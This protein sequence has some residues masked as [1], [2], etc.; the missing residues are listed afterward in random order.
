MRSPLFD[1]Y[2]PYG[3]VEQR[4]RRGMLPDEDGMYRR[5]RARLEDLMPPEERQSLLSDLANR[6]Q[7]AL[8]GLGWLLDVPGSLARG[9]ID[10]LMDG[11]PF[12]GVRTAFLPGES[13]QRVSGRDLLRR[14]NLAGGDDN[15]L[16][17]SAGLA[18]EVVTDPLFYLNP[19]AI[20]GRGAYSTA[21]RVANRA[22][23][24]DNAALMAH[25]EGMGVRE[26][27][28]SRTA[29]DL[30]GAAPGSADDWARAGG[31][32]SLLDQR[33]AG[34]MEL[35]VPGMDQGA[36]I[37]GGA[38]GDTLARGLDRFGEG[39]KYNPITGP[40][41]NRLRKNFDVSVMEQIN[42]D[43]QW[44][45]RE[46]FA[47]MQARQRDMRGAFA[48]RLD[49]AR[50]AAAPE[51]FAFDRRINN[52]IRDT[53]ERDLDPTRYGDIIDQEALRAID[54]TPAW[55]NYRQYLR[56]A[57]GEAQTRRAGQGLETPTAS[58][59]YDTA[60]APRQAVRF[61]REN[62]PEMN[63][64]PRDRSAYNRG[65]RVF[66]LDDVVGRSRRPYTD[67][68]GGS[69]TF[70]RLMGGPDAIDTLRDGA[71][72]R[73]RLRAAGDAEIPAILDAEFGRLGLEAPF[74]RV[75]DA[76]QANTLKVQLGDLL[77]TADNQYAEQGLGLFDNDLATD[78]LRYGVGGARSEANATVVLDNLLQAATDMPADNIPGG[79][80][81]NLIQ[82]ATDLGFN[83]TR[84]RDII[85]DR[86][87]GITP[88]EIAA[89]SVP[90]QT[91]RS[92]AAIAPRTAQA[93]DNPLSKL[94]RSF[95]GAFKVGALARPAYH[96]RNLYSGAL[97][98]LSGGEA[99]PLTAIPSWW[100]GFQA[101][102]GNYQ[103]A[104][105]IL[106]NAPG[107]R[108]LTDDAI[109]S[110]FLTGAAR[111][112]MS[113]GLISEADDLLSGAAAEIIPGASPPR[114]ANLYDS[115]RSLP[116][117]LRDTLTVRGVDF[118]LDKLF[119]RGGQ[120]FATRA[121]PAETL[122]PLLRLHEKV[123]THI[124]DANRLGTYIEMLRRGASPDAAARQVIKTQVDY[125]PQAYTQ[126]ERAAKK[127]IPFYSYTRGITPLAV[128]NL[129][130]RPGG[131]QGQTTRAITD[132]ARPR[133]DSFTPE[134]LRGTASIPLPGRMGDEGQL[135]RF[136]TNI[137]L[138]WTAPFELIDTGVGNTMAD[139]A[140]DAVQRTLMNIAG[141]T[142]PLIKGP[143]ELLVDR[144]LYS[145]R[146]MSDLYSWMAER[147]G[148][149]QGRLAEQALMNAPGGS[150]INALA[151]TLLDDRLPLSERAL[152]LAINNTLGLKVTD[153]DEQ[154][155]RE[156]AAR[157]MLTQLLRANP[158]VRT[159][160]NLSVP[161]EA[162]AAM[163]EEQRRLYLAYR[164]LQSQ[165]ARRARERRQ[166]TS[167]R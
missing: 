48:Q 92:L 83:D 158:G 144:Q 142:N 112:N 65:A 39:L 17:W 10:G 81:A 137:D 114:P 41:V 104:V 115:S 85:A 87:P 96:V 160:E 77:R 135:Q 38:L 164:V 79:G 166:L 146:E 150:Q 149:P 119:G 30:L 88:A 59:L 165:A 61:A 44:S 70:R 154:K 32:E 58:S 71:A 40:L 14:F 82:A 125:T 8:V 131:V 62:L 132:L 120:D 93:A 9:T 16:N 138:P 113:Q 118:G 76:A 31:R 167:V 152:K 35:R 53:L 153:I 11:D 5:R 22:G 105:N 57:L 136:I 26:Y 80:Y 103:P 148:S 162:L 37:S 25:R 97:S 27:L 90:E 42:P 72:L 12:R 60:Y 68:E 67:I 29:R 36:T 7:S 33:L 1:Q 101:G 130:Y 157:Q 106:R 102:R 34:L 161:D 108:G 109:R 134:S 126:F 159:Y 147:S 20:L 6:G 140:T 163:P 3:M 55:S 86:F 84:L 64:L 94:Y 49:A 78:F 24:L 121:A 13:D 100:A 107:Y 74:E 110:Q 47:G 129:L 122:S 23:L 18:T 156:Y 66:T 91:V 15:W 95:T 54:A 69:Q 4:A 19:A 46:A 151:R 141:T 99:N 128:E 124:E 116:E 143:L 28:R 133:D 63:R 127:L 111:N 43:A 56:D 117:F 139:R 73:D 45:A 155:S 51:G 123:G 2:D 52:A 145:G 89:M 21:G 75:G 98:T 50:Q